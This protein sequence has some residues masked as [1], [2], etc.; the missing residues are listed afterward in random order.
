MTPR[1]ANIAT[2]RRSILLGGLSAAAAAGLTACSGS[3]RGVRHAAAHPSTA[4]ASSGA[5]PYVGPL[6]ALALA[7]AL[8]NLAVQAYAVARTRAAGSG[9]GSVPPAVTAFLTAAQA[10]HR[11]HA[12]AWN[13][14]L[15]AGGAPPVTA[16]PLRGA[17]SLL[18]PFHAAATVHDLETAAGT[19]ELALAQT[20]LAAINGLTDAADLGLAAAVAPVEAQHAAILNMF[21]GTTPVPAATLSTGS[22]VSPD[23]LTA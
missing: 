23:T 21:L 3:S 17:A 20:C 11:E 8:D 5:S 14:R 18:A 4:P 16:V 15:S 12:S 7:A 19:L 2:S 13:A 9:Y 22:A 6:R 1:T 10:Q